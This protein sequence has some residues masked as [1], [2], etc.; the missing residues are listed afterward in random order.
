MTPPTRDEITGL[1]SLLPT[2][3]LGDI[4][5]GRIRA[6]CATATAVLDAPEV[7]L[8]AQQRATWGTCGICAQTQGEGCVYQNGD[9]CMPHNG[10]PARLAAAP[11][12][13]RLV[14]VQ[15]SDQPTLP[16]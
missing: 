16:A 1:L 14:P 11:K 9:P 6:L 3:I 4:I 15:E 8:S 10:H 2:Y 5:S 12:R 13:V 7:A